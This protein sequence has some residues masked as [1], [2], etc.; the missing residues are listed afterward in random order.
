L[1]KL[2]KTA[3]KISNWSVGYI[4]IIAKILFVGKANTKKS[5][6][7]S[8]LFLSGREARLR[9]PSGIDFPPQNQWAAL[10]AAHEMV[11]EKPRNLVL[12]WLYNL[13]RTHFSKNS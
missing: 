6:V 5:Q 7:M 1:L 12:V 2:T 10:R 8:N 4:T 9:A 11:S 13:T 3:I